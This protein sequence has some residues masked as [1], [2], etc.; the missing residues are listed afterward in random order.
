MSTNEDN[1]KAWRKITGPNTEEKLKSWRQA[2]GTGH[3]SEWGN[4]YCFAN[5]PSM[6]GY[7]SW[8]TQFDDVSRAAVIESKDSLSRPGELRDAY[9][10]L[11]D[12]TARH[13][14]F[15]TANMDP[16]LEKKEGEGWT[17]S[18]PKPP[19]TPQEQL[20]PPASSLTQ[21]QSTNQALPYLGSN[22]MVSALRGDAPEFRPTTWV[23]ER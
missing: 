5:H 6:A 12:E 2:T 4:K 10:A 8:P 1:L 21:D 14:S 9:N 18:T 20:S 19:S 15:W 17:C 3:G 23:A 13:A 11:D 22:R 7:S 16:E